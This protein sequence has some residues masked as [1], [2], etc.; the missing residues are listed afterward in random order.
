MKRLNLK[1]IVAVL[2][3]AIASIGFVLASLEK[4]VEETV[5]TK[6]QDE[7]QWYLHNGDNTY[8]D[9]GLSENPPASCTPP[10]DDPEICLKGFSPEN[11][12]GL[13]GVAAATGDVEIERQRINP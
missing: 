13:S 1:N 9:M 7:L 4:E 12:P 3:V 8:T 6:P 5:F 2:T 10:T 11:D